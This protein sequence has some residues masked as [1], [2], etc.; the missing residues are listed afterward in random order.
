MYFDHPKSSNMKISTQTKICYFTTTFDLNDLFWKSPIINY[1]DKLEGIIKK[2]I[3]LTHENKLELESYYNQLNSWKEKFS[4][5]I[6]FEEYILLSIDNI[7]AKPSFRDIRKISMGL[8]KKNVLKRK[9][10][11]NS[12][13]YN[14]IVCILRINIHNIFKEFHIKIFNTGKI[15]I[16]GIKESNDLN[17]I[18]D[19]LL[20]IFTQ[21]YPDKIIQYEQE[22]TQTILINANFHCGYIIDRSYLSNLLSTKYNLQC[23]YDPCTYQGIQCK[24]YYYVDDMNN[25]QNGI[26]RLNNNENHENI[27]E[28]TD[29]N[30]NENKYRII[31]CMIFRTGSILLVGNCNEIM[32]ENVYIFLNNLLKNEYRNEKLSEELT[33]IT[34]EDEP[35]PIKKCLRRTLYVYV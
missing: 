28:R 6:Y 15:E 2:Q 26:Y 23:F 33:K 17:I 20:T 22:K 13:F 3:K 10:K 7:Y 1:D 11:L 14:C 34:N 18:I 8:C 30:V 27:E 35:H 16:P 32:I 21:M 24:F 25:Q 4:N 31:S 19:K 5:S 29:D 9:P 12:A